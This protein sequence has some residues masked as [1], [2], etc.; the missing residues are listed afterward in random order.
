MNITIRKSIAAL[1]I[2][3]GM[4]ATAEAYNYGYPVYS[5]A[6]YY[7]P[8]VYRQEPVMYCQQPV[9]YESVICDAPVMVEPRYVFKKYKRYHRHY[10]RYYPRYHRRPSFGPR[11]SF[12]MGF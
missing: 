1:M 6:P 12:S 11:F 4:S 5:Y 2:V 10:P 3:I 9:V 7:Q 8:V